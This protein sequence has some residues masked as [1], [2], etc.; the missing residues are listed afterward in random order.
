MAASRIYNHQRIFFFIKVEGN[1]FYK[2]LCR[3]FKVDS[4][5]AA[6]NA[7]SLIKH[8]RLFVPIAVFGKAADCGKG[9]KRNFTAVKKIV[10]NN[11]N[12]H[13]ERS[14]RTDARRSDDIARK[15]GFKAARFIARAFKS[16]HN[17]ADKGGRSF[18]LTIQIFGIRT[19]RYERFAAADVY[20]V[21]FVVAGIIYVNGII[22]RCPN[23]G[24]AVLPDACGQYFAEIVIGVVAADFAASRRTEKTQGCRIRVFIVRSVA[25]VPLFGQSCIAALLS[26]KNAL[27]RSIQ[28]LE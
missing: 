19:V 8:A 18:F 11:A 17:A 24:D 21:V 6:Q 2:R 15:T 9:R 14:G 20:A 3:I 5:K 28:E 23:D 25:F 7:S 16:L 1:F 12:K 4:D 22:V 10:Q 13:F 27:F 26:G